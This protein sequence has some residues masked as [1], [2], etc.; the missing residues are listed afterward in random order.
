MDAHGQW[1][2]EFLLRSPDTENKDN[3]IKDVLRMIS[4]SDLDF[5]IKKIFLL[6]TLQN[7]FSS[8]SITETLLKTLELLEEVFRCDA[9]PVTAT[10]SAAYCAV[11]VECT[12]KYLQVNLYNHN[13]PYL[14]AVNRIWQLRIPQMI[15]SG[16]REGSLLFSVELEQ[17]RK[18]IET[19]LLDLQVRERLASID[20]RRDA[21][22]KFRAFLEEAWTV[23]DSSFVPLAATEHKL[24]QE[25]EVQKCSIVAAENLHLP[26]TIEVEKIGDCISE[27]LL[28][29]DSLAKIVEV[30]KVRDCISGELQDMAKNSL[31]TTVEVEKVGDCISGEVQA[32]AKD[33]LTTTMEDN[34]DA[35]QTVE[36]DVSCPQDI[37]DNE[38]DPVEKGQASIPSNCEQRPNLM[39]KNSTA[40]VDEWDSIDGLEGVSRF[41]L[42]SPKRRKLP[43]LETYKPTDITKRRKAKRWSQLE[44]E[45]LKNGVEKFGKGNWKLI[46]NAHQDIFEERTEVDL[47]DKWRN[48][49]RYGFANKS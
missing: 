2:L 40:R 4:V 16:S 23:M 45:T 17:W 41:N 44:E 24:N 35:R 38:A 3:L 47:K 22:I 49:T 32:L 27:E 7:D 36:A 6:K 29:K 8:H 28:A 10:M 9:S 26:K 39:E 37:N 43:P 5:R 1:L 20:T 48:M 34:E 13:A 33:T 15:G 30:E 19:S 12:I 31:P 14:R 25:G 11:A 21:I 42:P 46:L 18:D